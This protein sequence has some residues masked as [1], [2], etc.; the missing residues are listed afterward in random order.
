MIQLS[1]FKRLGLAISM[2]LVS[3]FAPVPIQA[4]TAAVCSEVTPGVSSSV[5]LTSEGTRLRLMLRNDSTSTTISDILL[6][7]SIQTIGT[8]L[9][10]APGTHYAL[11]PVE[12]V[13]GGV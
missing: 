9:S 4:S 8:G 5:V 11:P 7:P 1:P 12:D 13:C 10:L 2:C 6:E 3:T